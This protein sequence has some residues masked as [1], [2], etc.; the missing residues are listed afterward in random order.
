M[1]I[2]LENLQF[3]EGPAFA[4]NG[5]LWF[6]EQ[7]NGSLSEYSS[8]KLRRHFVGGRPNGIAFDSDGLLWFCD[9][10]RNEIRTYDPISDSTKTVISHIG[11]ENLNLPNDLAFDAE[12]NLLFTCSGE[13]LHKG[14]GY[15]CAWNPTMGLTKIDSVPFYPNG[16]AFDQDG[17]VLYVAE[18]GTKHIWKGKWDSG[19]FTWK[20]P[21]IFTNTG[22]SVGPDGIAFDEEG[23]LYVA[24][25]GSSK[26]H[27]YHQNGN[28]HKEI[29]LPG[30]NPTN[31]AFDPNGKLG[32]VIT[33]A[34]KGQLLSYA[35]NSRGIL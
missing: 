12:G 10:L 23:L 1:S 30:A 25:F 8:G 18:T 20:N 35:T 24:V 19:A 9:S 7:L 13:E 31:C 27:V 32:L 34:E 11:N 3:P 26:V 5:T 17:T 14:D 2:L 6:V 4:P 28:L 21:E 33:E 16:L 29:Q 15:F 22:G